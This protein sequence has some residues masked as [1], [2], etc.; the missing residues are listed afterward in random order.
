MTWYPN[1]LAC[2][3]YFLEVGQLSAGSQALAAF[4]NIRLPCQR[5][6][7]PQHQHSAP[8]IPP[9]QHHPNLVN[10]PPQLAP[11]N[12]QDP[13]NPYGW[14]SLYPYIRRLVATGFDH[15][16]ILEGW[17]GER[18]L[19]GI[20]PL[21]EQERRNYLFAAKMFGGWG[22]VK[23]VYD[24]VSDEAVPFLQPLKNVEDEEI[25]GAEQAWSKWLAMEDWMLGRSR[26]LDD[27]EEHHMAP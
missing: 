24:S 15:P 22:Q 18:W 5:E 16:D 27:D 12:P 1:Y 19:E 11:P 10:T 21:H 14:V 17:F 13:P 26:G 3:K 4:I 23:R 25:D 8:I 2:Q 6:P 9:P 7:K 20:G